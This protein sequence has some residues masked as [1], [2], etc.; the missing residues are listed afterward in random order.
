MIWAPLTSQKQGEGEVAM[1][2]AP[3]TSTLI[4][5][6]AWIPFVPLV[7][8]LWVPQP[9]SSTVFPSFHFPAFVSCA[10]TSFATIHTLLCIFKKKILKFCV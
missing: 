5:L 2:Q 8:P 6:V 3:V 1:G 7:A 10:F 9:F 4:T